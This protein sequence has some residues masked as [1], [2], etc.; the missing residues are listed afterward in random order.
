MK[1]AII[2]FLVTFPWGLVLG[3]Y[4][5]RFDFV[6]IRVERLATHAK[7]LRRKFRAWMGR[8]E[9]PQSEETI[10]GD[11]PRLPKLERM[12]S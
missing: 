2:T 1:T 11:I 3:A 7:P 8:R 4:L 12:I 6:R 9:K 5:M 10:V